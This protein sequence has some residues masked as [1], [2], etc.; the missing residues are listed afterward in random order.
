M[1]K[2]GSYFQ[3]SHIRNFDYSVNNEL[4]KNI[5]KHMKKFNLL[6]ALLFIGLS[7]TAQLTKSEAKWEKIIEEKNVFTVKQLTTEKDTS[8]VLF[9][10]NQKYKSI[11][12]T[13]SITFTTLEELKVFFTACLDV[14]ENEEAKYDDAQ[15]YISGFGKRTAY[16]SLLKKSAYFT[17][18]EKQINNAIAKLD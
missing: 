15:I 7:A 9:F 13:E 16:I 3:H 5:Q 1:D 11:V 18:N 4:I 10:F 6:F 14:C 2:V 12:V 8:Y 17:L